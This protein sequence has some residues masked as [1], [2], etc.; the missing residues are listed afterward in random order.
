VWPIRS[1]FSMRLFFELRRVLYYSFLLQ[2]MFP[3]AGC[4][5]THSLIHGSGGNATNSSFIF[6]IGSCRRYEFWYTIL[7]CLDPVYYTV[8][9]TCVFQNYETQYNQ[10]LPTRKI[11]LSSTLKEHYEFKSL[12][13]CRPQNETKQQRQGWTPL[14]FHERNRPS[15]VN[16]FQKGR[17]YWGLD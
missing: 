13:T 7:M 3:V 16:F 12:W 15:S 2:T 17:I 5:T 10:T 4:N 1:V 9:R 11:P 14:L 8:Y 6:N